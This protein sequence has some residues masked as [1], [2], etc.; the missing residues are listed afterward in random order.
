MPYPAPVSSTTRVRC[1]NLP[2]IVQDPA[3]ATDGM[4]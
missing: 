4:A 2:H 3:Y 1:G